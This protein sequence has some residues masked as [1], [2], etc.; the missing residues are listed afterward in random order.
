[1]NADKIADRV[2]DYPEPR[3][4]IERENFPLSVIDHGTG[5]IVTE[6]PNNQ[7][8]LK[9]A[10]GH[11]IEQNRYERKVTELSKLKGFESDVAS[12]I[13]SSEDGSWIEMERVNCPDDVGYGKIV[14]PNSDLIHERLRNHG[15]LLYEVETGYI[16][17]NAVAYDYGTVT[18][19]KD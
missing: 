17:E 11:G 19:I 5:R 10:V 12:V 9:F 18:T 4:A 15:V 8:I 1:M 13:N 2:K 3:E 14:G 16:G 7:N 6:N